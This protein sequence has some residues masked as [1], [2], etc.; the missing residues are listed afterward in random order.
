MRRARLCREHLRCSVLRA[1]FP[2]AS[3]SE[4]ATAPRLCEPPWDAMFCTLFADVAQLV[5]QR[6]RKP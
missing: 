5:E 4:S 1:V 3:R 6:F 2:I